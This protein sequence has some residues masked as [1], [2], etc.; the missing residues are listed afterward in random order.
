MA[1]IHLD[2]FHWRLGTFNLIRRYRH[3][4]TTVT[5]KTRSTET[6]S[7]MTLMNMLHGIFEKCNSETQGIVIDF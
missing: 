7:I 5:I 2:I 6:G 1:R 4:A 3:A